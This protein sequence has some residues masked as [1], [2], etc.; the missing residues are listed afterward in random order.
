MYEHL[1]MLNIIVTNKCNLSCSYCYEQHSKDSGV[2]DSEKLNKSLDFLINANNV[3]ARKKFQ[4]FGGEPLLNKKLIIDFIKENKEKL[5]VKH[6]DVS[7]VTN[8]LLADKVFLD[9]FFADCSMGSR[10][11]ILV[12][13][14]DYTSDTDFRKL[15]DNQISYI[16]HLFEYCN[17]KGYASNLSIRTT[18]PKEN[19]PHLRTFIK[20]IYENGIR[21]IVIHPL[22]LSNSDGY[23]EWSNEEWAE[24]STII[25]ETTSHYKDLYFEFAEGVGSKSG[26]SCVHN[27][28]TLS[29][30]ADGDISGCY[31]FSNHK[32]DDFGRDYQV[33]NIFEGTNLIEKTSKYD[34]MFKEMQATDPMCQ[35]CNVKD[36]CY[37]CPAGNLAAFGVLFKPNEMCKKIVHLFD[38]IERKKSISEAFE[39]YEDV[40]KKV[41]ENNFVLKVILL[42]MASVYGTQE[43][44]FDTLYTDEKDFYK[45]KDKE[46]IENTSFKDILS[47]IGYSINNKNFD[48]SKLGNCEYVNPMTLLIPDYNVIDDDVLTV[49]SLLELSRQIGKKR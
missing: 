11:G 43:K 37:Q 7:I 20:K 35:S 46:L 44:Y 9:D 19:L 5:K 16:F 32:D 22:I 1:K 40:T 17:E 41:K 21:S 13:L 30:T 6:V 29:V 39:L 4:F 47:F 27:M 49:F 34:E 15:T 12:S 25:D 3:K 38:L 8:F 45:I 42:N 31:F 2:W 28:D 23:I 36:L 10:R 18:L 48:L 14:D 24:L 26:N 33:G